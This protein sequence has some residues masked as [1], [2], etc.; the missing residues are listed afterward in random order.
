MGNGRLFAEETERQMIRFA[1]MERAAAA[2]KQCVAKWTASPIFY[3]T[4]GNSR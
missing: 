1:I 3:A 2:L 4:E